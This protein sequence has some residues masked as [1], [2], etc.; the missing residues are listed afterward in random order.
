M[1]VSETA[2]LVCELRKRQLGLSKDLFAEHW[3][4]ADLKQKVEKF[5]DDYL[6]EASPNEDYGV[7][8]RGL[9]FQKA[10]NE[11]ISD[12]CDQFINIAAGFT[13]Y[14]LNIESN[15]KTY[16]LDL[17][18]IV[19]EKTVALQKENFKNAKQKPNF[20]DID[21]NDTDDF[22]DKIS[23]IA[24]SKSVVFMEGISYYLTGEVFLETLKS[25]KSIIKPGS[26][27]VMDYWD[28]DYLRSEIFLKQSNFFKKYYE[29]P[30]SYLLLDRYEIEN[31]DGFEVCSLSS[32][33]TEAAINQVP[34][35]KY[36][37]LPE[38]YAVLKFIGS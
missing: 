20:I 15:I 18:H 14:S 27:L 32:A 29:I 24:K 30:E 37:F 11:A 12:G 2:Y 33:L 1:G 17:Q 6:A 8:L 35:E 21:L 10:L 34:P 38:N 26:Y 31:L 19:Q 9:F 22:S 4:P 36:S 5:T 7:S 25:L 28:S 23:T 3:I 16:E 13:S